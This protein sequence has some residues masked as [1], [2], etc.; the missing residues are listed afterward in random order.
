MEASDRFDVLTGQFVD[1][2]KEPAAS[3]GAPAIE[4]GGG[5]LGRS[6][7]EDRDLGKD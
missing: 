7:Y 2:E 1:L 3:E 5:D 4:A 6:P